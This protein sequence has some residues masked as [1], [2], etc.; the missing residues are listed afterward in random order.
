MKIIDLEKKL[1]ITREQVKECDKD[2]ENLQS[3]I[4]SHQFYFDNKSLV[5]ELMS[6]MYYINLCEFRNFIDDYIARK[7]LKKKRSAENLG[8]PSSRDKKR[9]TEVLPS[10]VII[11]FKTDSN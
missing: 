7:T 3:L 9:R 5:E 11:N 4:N 8:I 6:H 1:R 2:H 10:S